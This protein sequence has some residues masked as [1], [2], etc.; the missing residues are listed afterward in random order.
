MSQEN[1]LITIFRS[2]IEKSLL[3][4]I[5]SHD[6]NLQDWRRFNSLLSNEVINYTE[7]QNYVDTLPSAPVG[8]QS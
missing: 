5:R 6:G 2:F 3:P 7:L 8:Y 4:Q 1:R